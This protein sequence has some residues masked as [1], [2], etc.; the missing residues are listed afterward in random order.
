[1]EL[2]LGYLVRHD[3][4][5]CTVVYWN[6]L[7]ND[8]RTFVQLRLK[9][10]ETGRLTELKEGTDTKWE[11]LE[12]EERELTHSY[13]DGIV[14]VFFMES[15]EELR[16]PIAAA[17]D[18]LRW[19]AESY[20]G[21]FIEDA[22]VAVHPPKYCTLEITETDPSM[23]GGGSGSKD[24]VLENGVKVKVNLLCNIGD[25]VRV[26]TETLEVKERVTK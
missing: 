11:V 10:L 15:G 21:M 7:R 4:R 2:R 23:K 16:C 6:I 3:G 9:D 5:M 20:Q 19:P 14:E 12:R 25:R 26:E 18:A 22:L 1:M 13:R 17:E 24:A 8:R